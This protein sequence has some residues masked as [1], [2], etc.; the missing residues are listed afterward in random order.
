[1]ISTIHFEHDQKLASASN[2][3]DTGM[4]SEVRVVRAVRYDK[5]RHYDSEASFGWTDMPYK[6]RSQY[7]MS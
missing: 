1:M 3:C 5:N 2:L 6:E 7:A 4:T